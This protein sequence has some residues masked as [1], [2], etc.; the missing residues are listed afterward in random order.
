MLGA[1][2]AV[3]ELARRRTCVFYGKLCPLR[4]FFVAFDM[5]YPL[6]APFVIIDYHPQAL[7][8]RAKPVIRVKIIA[9]FNG[10]YIVHKFCD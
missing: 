3:P 7:L 6:G 10:K 2:I 8:N 4:E 9:S 1:D 5:N